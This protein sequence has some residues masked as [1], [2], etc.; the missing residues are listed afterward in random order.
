M[1]YVIDLGEGYDLPPTKNP[2]SNMTNH[3]SLF[4]FLSILPTIHIHRS[5]PFPLCPWGLLLPWHYNLKV[6]LL[7]WFKVIIHFKYKKFYIRTVL[8][9]IWWRKCVVHCDCQLGRG[10]LIKAYDKY[11][12][13]CKKSIK[14]RYKVFIGEEVPWEL[15]IWSWLAYCLDY[16]H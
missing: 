15:A 13:G 16:N 9:D 6:R 1:W 7:I 3:P 14:W 5:Y 2:I 4:S 8:L 12:I 11:R 10:I